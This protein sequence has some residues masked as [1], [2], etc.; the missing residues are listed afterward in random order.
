MHVLE[1]MHRRSSRAKAKAWAWVTLVGAL[2]GGI[3]V[4]EPRD[5]RT[6]PAPSRTG[7]AAL[8][9]VLANRRSVR[10][11]RTT[12]LPDD[13]LA[14]LVWAAQGTTREGHRTAPSAGARYPLTVWIADAQGVWRYVPADH[15][16]VRARADD[17]RAAIVPD[18]AAF[19]R[20]PAIL[21]I[22]GEVA[23]TARKYGGRAER[24]VMLEAGHAAQ[25]VLLTAT[26]LELGAV[27]VGAFDDRA[28][29]RALGVGREVL[30]LYVIPIGT[31]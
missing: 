10:A 1:G 24:Y 4:A 17:Q 18:E 12:P 13:A 9:D 22:T 16:L 23:I 8:A 25:N 26:A 27:P 21:V 7:G 2:V 29:R 11:F 5:R 15:V 19:A 6:L 3:A 31:P 28:V 20:A 14:Q 30:P